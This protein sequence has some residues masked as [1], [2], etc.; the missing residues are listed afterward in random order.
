MQRLGSQAA[1]LRATSFFR[2]IV[3]ESPNLFEREVVESAY[4]LFVTMVEA[5]PIGNPPKKIGFFKPLYLPKHLLDMQ[6]RYLIELVNC[7]A[8]PETYEHFEVVAA[9]FYRRNWKKPF[10]ADEF[11]ATQER[12]KK[13]PLLYSAWGIKLYGELIQLLKDTYPILYD[14]QLVKDEPEDDGVKMYDLLDA[15]SKENPNAWEESENL[16]LWRAFRWMEVQKE[17]AIIQENKMKRNGSQF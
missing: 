15:L 2:E 10:N 14:D 11:E 13:M 16:P 6:V 17:K 9:C 4:Q 5:D 3:K 1:H 12:F 7:N 8:N